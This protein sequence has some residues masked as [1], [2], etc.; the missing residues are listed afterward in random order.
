MTWLRLPLFITVM[1]ALLVAVPFEGAGSR[2]SGLGA[3]AF[4][5][6]RWFV[7]P[8]TLPVASMFVFTVTA[9]FS[10]VLGRGAGHSADNDGEAPLT[11]PDGSALP[12]WDWPIPASPQMAGQS[13]CKKVEQRKGRQMVAGKFAEDAKRVL[14]YKGLDW[15][16]SEHGFEQNWQIAVRELEEAGDHDLAAAIKAGGEVFD[17]WEI[18]RT[19]RDEG[20]LTQEETNACFAEVRPHGDRIWAILKG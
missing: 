17:R 4:A 2:G 10:F 15:Y 16:L 9:F 5:I 18:I 6:R 7:E 13:F 3:F 19:S 12:S 20:D 14:S 1:F 8:I 11:A